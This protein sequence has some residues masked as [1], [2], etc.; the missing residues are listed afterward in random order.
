MQHF[1]RLVTVIAATAAALT[2]APAANA[3]ST[4]DTVAAENASA[5]V[6][7]RY[8]DSQARGWETAIAAG[9]A[10]WNNNVD[11]VKLTKAQPGTRAEIQIVATS[12]WPQATIGPVRPGGRG[13]VEL[14]S[15]AVGQGYDKTRIAAHEIGHNLG[16]PDTKPGPCSQLMSGSTGG[17][18]CKNAV[19]NAA[20]QAR[21][22]GFYAN[23]AA[24]RVPASGQL[25]VDAP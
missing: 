6:T 5:V 23:G 21:V 2:A 22:E 10:S 17:V 4:H 20:E 3:V 15:Q 12:G 16:L 1:R 7:L 11:N 8:D 14:G 19:P 25:V 9:V 24:T 13:R 18:S